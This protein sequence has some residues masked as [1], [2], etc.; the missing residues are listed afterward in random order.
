MSFDGSAYEGSSLWRWPT[1]QWRMFPGRP[2]AL[3]YPM[4]PAL[5]NCNPNLRP[6]PP[7]QPMAPLDISPTTAGMLIRAIEDYEFTMHSLRRSIAPDVPP[8]LDD[9]ASLNY[10]LAGLLKSLRSI[11]PPE[12][13]SE[14]GPFGELLTELT[15]SLEILKTIKPPW[16]SGNA[17][18]FTTSMQYK[19]ILES[20]NMRL[21]KFK[22]MIHGYTF[23]PF[24]PAPENDDISSMLIL[25]TVRHIPQPAESRR[26]TAENSSSNASSGT[27]SI[28]PAFVSLWNRILPFGFTATPPETAPSQ[29]I[30]VHEPQRLPIRIPTPP[31][32][33]PIPISTIP[34]DPALKAATDWY[35]QHIKGQ[36]KR[37]PE[38]R[39][40]RGQLPQQAPVR[41]ILYRQRTRDPKE[42]AAHIRRM[43]EANELA[44]RAGEHANQQ[45]AQS[46]GS[47][48]AVVSYRVAHQAAR[49]ALGKTSVQPASWQTVKENDHETEQP[50][51]QQF[52]NLEAQL[53]DATRL[54]RIENVAHI[55]AT[56]AM[57]AA[58]PSYRKRPKSSAV[59]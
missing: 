16:R 31:P 32:T 48:N 9:I 43:K 47:S 57:D 13:R 24:P 46:S 49:E 17:S 10:H 7:P 30:A 54:V 42:R 55:A 12:H 45:A 51:N 25:D 23:P 5:N 15:R 37:S 1:L 39:P 18:S 2:P 4:Q 35:R 52:L 56:T 27:K 38:R 14:S 44:E 21:K 28:T 36:P 22:D 58:S 8:C 41:P 33:L 59:A 20:S 34:S 50:N 40:R 26:V 19:C 6:I 29:P 3:V 11:L 53:P